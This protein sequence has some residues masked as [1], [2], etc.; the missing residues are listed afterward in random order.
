MSQTQELSGKVALITGSGK[1]IGRA[2]ALSLAE[3]G[4]SISINT[5]SS[6]SEAQSVRSEIL[7]HGG[8]AEVFIAD[9][10]DPNSVKTMIEGTI[11]AFGRLDILVLNASVRRE[12]KF[13]DMDFEEWRRVMSTSLDASFHCIK[14]CLPHLI[15]AGAGHIITIGGDG[16]LDGSIGKAH[17]STAKCGLIGLGKALAKELAPH[18]IRVNCV[19]PGAINTTRPSH[20]TV[21]S[22]NAP[23][24][25]LGR[26]G[27]PEEIAA[28]VRFLCGPGGGFMT[29]QV[30][31]M[32]GGTLMGH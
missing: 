2:I 20:R 5:R 13:I 21:R 10:T 25:P 11:A 3:A 23:H 6:E 19:S 4:A 8:K 18:Q 7:S 9:I 15:K 22:T 17:S 31:H 1:N 12:V 24:I 29:G 28:G 16:A 26:Y 30:I 14:A 27:E 32:N